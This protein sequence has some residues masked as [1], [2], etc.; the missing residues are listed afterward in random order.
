VRNGIPDEA[1][2]SLFAADLRRELETSDSSKKQQYEQE[3][4]YQPQAPARVVAP[5]S[6]VR[7]RRQAA[8]TQQQKDDE[9]YD[10]HFGLPSMLHSTRIVWLEQSV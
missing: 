1:K 9:Q 8:Q 3:Y 5:A 10:Q 4:H 7:P 6:A 2:A